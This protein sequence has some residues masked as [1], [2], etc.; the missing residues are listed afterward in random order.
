[1]ETIWN[2]KFQKNVYSGNIFFFLFFIEMYFLQI[3]FFYI[4]QTFSQEIFISL[5]DM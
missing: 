1:M 3:K 4:H 2:K 5:I